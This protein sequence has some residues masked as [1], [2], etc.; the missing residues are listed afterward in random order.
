LL[1]AAQACYLDRVLTTN[2]VAA[3][4]GVS[5][6]TV[7]REIGRGNL[8]AEKVGTQ[9]VITEAEA[10]RWAAKYRPYAEQRDRPRTPPTP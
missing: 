8:A 4:A 9:W 1:S 5:R 3:K 10:D 6:H 7:D 2:Q